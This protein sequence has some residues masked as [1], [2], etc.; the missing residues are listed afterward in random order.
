MP[1]LAAPERIDGF[2]TLVLRSEGADLEA[3]FVPTDGNIVASLRDGGEELLGSGKGLR[4]YARN[5][6]TMGIPLLHPW[7]NRLAGDT[8]D[9]ARKLVP[10]GLGPFAAA[11]SITVDRELL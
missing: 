10:G 7:A 6:A 5:G 8:Y 11:F 1:R 3:A 9:A 4:R 2:D